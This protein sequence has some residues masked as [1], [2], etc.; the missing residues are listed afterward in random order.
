MP[1]V[2]KEMMPWSEEYKAYEETHKHK[3]ESYLEYADMSV[4][5]KTPRKKDR[6]TVA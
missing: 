4:K 1:V 6:V 2:L 5:P 3:A